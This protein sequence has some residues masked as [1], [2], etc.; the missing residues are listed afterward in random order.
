MPLRDKAFVS[1]VGLRGAVPI[2]LAT[3][4]VTAGVPGSEAFFNIVFFV[5]VVSVILQGT[6]IPWVARLLKVS[7][8]PEDDA[9]E[10]RVPQSTI[11]L[12]LNGNSPVVGRLVVD[13]KLPSSALLLLLRRDGESC[14]PRGSTVLRDGDGILVAT[15][16]DDADDL[17]RMIE[18]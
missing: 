8:A 16:K 10:A 13:L 5:V 4:P 11:E 6:T 2:V 17:R 9:E 12:V 14:I 7:V 3:I 18:G 1:W 15:R